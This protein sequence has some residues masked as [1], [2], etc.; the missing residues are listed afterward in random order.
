[1]MDEYDVEDELRSKEYKRFIKAWFEYIT[2]YDDD[3]L[4]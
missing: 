3:L 1:M 2:D 4:V